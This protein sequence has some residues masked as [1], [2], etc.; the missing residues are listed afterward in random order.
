MVLESTL[1][2]PSEIEFLFWDATRPF[3]NSPLPTFLAEEGKDHTA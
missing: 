2:E 3:A 1:N